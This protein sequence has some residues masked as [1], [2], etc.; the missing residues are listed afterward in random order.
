MPELP[1]VETIKRQLGEKIKGLVIEKVEVRKKRLFKGESKEIIGAK[2]ADVKRRAKMLIIDLKKSHLEFLPA[3]RQGISGSNKNK[4]IPKQVRNDIYLLIHL[5]MSGQL[6]FVDKSGKY[7][8]SSPRLR[9]VSVKH[10]F[11]SK[12]NNKDQIIVPNKYTHITMFFKSGEKLYYNDLRQ[13]GWIKVVDEKE[14]ERQLKKNGS[15][16]LDKDFS[17]NKFEE[18]IKTKKRSKIKPTLMDQSLIAGIGNIY[19]SEICFY[20][21][22]MPDR[23]ISNLSEYEL[24]KLYKGIKKI[25]SAAIKHQGTSTDLYV[26]LAGQ[27]GK[28]ESYLQVYGRE[29]EKCERGECVGKVKKIKMAQ[30]ST[31]YCDKCQK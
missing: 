15:E 9:G 12:F 24:K 30:R 5:K 22:V 11:L 8:P 14:L 26:N 20:A 1:E 17:L 19:A 27:K 31:Y 7:G 10:T 21:G 4:K 28:Y 16:P 2:I 25:L 3:G 13:F 23:I 18:I 6:I 29:K